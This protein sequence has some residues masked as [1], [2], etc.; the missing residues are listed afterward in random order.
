MLT[1]KIIHIANPKNCGFR[2]YF[3]C[4]IFSFLSLPVDPNRCPNWVLFL[5]DGSK[6]GSNGS[7]QYTVLPSK[8]KRRGQE[9]RPE[10]DEQ[11]KPKKTKMK[12][13]WTKRRFP[14]NKG[15]KEAKSENDESHNPVDKE[16]N[17]LTASNKDENEHGSGGMK[18]EPQS[19]TNE[20]KAS[21]LEPNGSYKDGK[22]DGLT[23]SGNERFEEPREREIMDPASAQEVKTVAA[24]GDIFSVR[25][26]K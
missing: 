17:A 16:E 3:F 19:Q 2:L 14:R 22:H 20:L 23:T 8:K 1:E 13:K 26:E 5:A 25:G 21:T 4:I 9:S 7:S 10:T 11:L 6:M 24:G 15:D 18:D 12:K